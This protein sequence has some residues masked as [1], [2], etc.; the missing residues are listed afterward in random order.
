[1]SKKINVFI[2]KNKALTEINTR[3]H[4]ELKSLR[5]SMRNARKSAKRDKLNYKMLQLKN[6]DLLLKLQNINKL[7]K[8]NDVD[9]S[10]EL[11]RKRRNLL[12]ENNLSI[13]TYFANRGLLVIFRLPYFYSMFMKIFYV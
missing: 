10:E 1:M 6:K 3:S 11:P 2:K 7:L 9:H 13:T 4:I 5:T 12:K 8:I